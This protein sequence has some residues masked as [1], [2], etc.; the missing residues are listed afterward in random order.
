MARAYLADARRA[1]GSAGYSQLLTALKVYKQDD[2]FDKVL[3]VL[4]A[5]TTARPE[6]FSL[7]QRFSIF[8]RPHHKQRLLQACTDLTGLPARGTPRPGPEKPER[9]EKGQSKISSFLSR[10]PAGDAG[11]GPSRPTQPLPRHAQCR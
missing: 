3:A 8:V 7:L 9:P 2:D 4:A 10:R 5:L 6:D 11:A 1:L